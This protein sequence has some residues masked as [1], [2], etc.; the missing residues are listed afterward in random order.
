MLTFSL[1]SKSLMS[2]KISHA[3]RTGTT[4]QLEELIRRSMD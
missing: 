1:V 4:V 3:R 2:L